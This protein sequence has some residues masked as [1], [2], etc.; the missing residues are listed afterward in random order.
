LNQSE[1][2]GIA[3]PLKKPDSRTQWTL[4]IGFFDFLASSSPSI[5]DD[6]DVRKYFFRTGAS[7]FLDFLAKNHPIIQ[8]KVEFVQLSTKRPKSFF[9]LFKCQFSRYVSIRITQ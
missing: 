5:Q 9:L 6:F 3:D 4:F 1:I 2:Q 7:H 8:F